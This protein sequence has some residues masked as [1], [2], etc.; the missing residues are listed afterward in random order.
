MPATCRHTYKGGDI[1]KEQR[2]QH[3]DHQMMSQCCGGNMSQCWQHTRDKIHTFSVCVVSEWRIVVTVSPKRNIRNMQKEI[4]ATEIML[5]Q[6][7]QL[8]Q[9]A[10]VLFSNLNRSGTV[11]KP[12]GLMV[13]MRA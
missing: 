12:N 10:A 2:W 9:T 3:H 6:K 8:Q 7:Q 1:L 13:C 11:R 5:K 4:T